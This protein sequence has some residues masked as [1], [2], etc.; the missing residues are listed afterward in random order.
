M[1]FLVFTHRNM[2]GFVSQ[3]VGGLEHRIGKQADRGA[4]GVL[5]SLVLELGHPLDPAHAGD[6]VED[7]GKLDM[8]EHR[9]LREDDRLGRVHTG[10]HEGGGDLAGLVDQRAGLDG[11]RDS[12]QVHDA[13]DAV[14][15][16]NT[17]FGPVEAGGVSVMVRGV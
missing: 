15:P 9:G 13:E 6:A 1:L 7:P 17:R 14:M 16:E 11:H 3:N 5:T 8:R 4:L 12:V 2:R 10:G